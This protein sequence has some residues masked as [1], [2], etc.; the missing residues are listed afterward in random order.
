L[1]KNIKNGLLSLFFPAPCAACG[2]YIKDFRYLYVCPECYGG[3]RKLDGPVCKTCMK[4]MN[5]EFMTE[6]RECEEGRRYFTN[7]AAAGVYSGALKEL[8]HLTKFYDRKKTAKLLADFIFE[9]VMDAAVKWAGVIVPV[10]LSKSALSERG[11]NQTALVAQILAERAG[12]RY[13]EAV[14]KVRETEPQNKL[15]RK[16]RLKNLKGAFEAS[17]GVAGMKVL[18]VDDVYTTGATMNEMAKTLLAAGAAEVRGIVVAR[19]V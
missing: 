2:R 18:V 14:K 19:S 15:E 10:P 4:P 12:V 7:I 5:A 11:Y 1:I 16:D 3:I 9:N 13:T 6:C 8:I 17:A